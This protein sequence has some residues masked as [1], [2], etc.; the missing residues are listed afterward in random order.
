MAKVEEPTVLFGKSKWIWSMNAVDHVIMRRVFSFGADRPPVRAL[1]RAA[2]DTHYCIYVNGNAA[3]WMG[4]MNRGAHAYYDEFDISKFLVKGD[5]VIV[6]YCMH[7]STDGR[8]LVTSGRPAFIFECNDI[9][10]YSDETFSVYENP[11]YKKPSP[12]NCCFAGANLNYDAAFE[13]QIQN[14]LDPAFKSSLFQ[15]AT[16]IDGYP[17]NEFG[18]LLPRPLPM[19]RFSHTPVIVKPKKSTDQFDGDFYTINLPRYMRITPYIEVIG[20]G[21][22]PIVVKTDRTDCQGCFGDEKSIYH[23]HFLQYTTKPTV[24]IFD[25]MLP[26]S[27]ETLYFSMPHTVK[28]LK[29]GYREISYD[30]DPT[31]EFSTGNEVYDKLFDKAMNTLYACMGSTIMDSPER[32][33]TMWLGDSSIAARALYLGYADAAHLVRKVI[34]DI[35]ENA[36]GDILRS[37]VPG[38]V[39]V[40]IPSH[41]LFALSEYGIFAQSR[42]FTQDLDLFKAEFTRLCDYL[43]QWEMTEHGVSLRDGNRRWYDNLYNIDETLVENALYYSACKFLLSVGEKLGDHEYDETFSDRMENIADFIESSW[44]GLGYTSRDDGYDDRANA[45]IVLDGLVPSD[46][47]EAI[48]RLLVSTMEASPYMEWAPIEALS[49]LGRRDLALK[50]FMSRYAIAADDGSSVLGEDFNG[51]GAKCQAYQSAVIFELISVFGGISVK[52]GSTEIAVTPDFT[53]LKDF[54]CSLK[55]ESGKLDVRYKY[56]P[57]RIDIIIDNDT[58]AKVTLDVAPERIG[59]SVERR[60]I[61]L[62]KGKNKFTI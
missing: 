34:D 50:R 8:D 32:E 59:R 58:S 3:V 9:D 37:C 12:S 21:Q 45:L 55:L 56:S 23:A 28:V 42:N 51:Y 14:L 57:A 1:C 15:T 48:A 22:E 27:G 17:S 41:G 53:A 43:M 20:E 31:C 2:C 62:N 35:F 18:V 61:T 6:V 46:R 4:G 19:E 38:N 24:N 60:T 49:A 30:T 29:L 11:A 7:Y 47:K 13:G 44:D 40:D 16:V 52:N 54:K 5:N 26:M 39:P 10:V 25:C 36:D 33:R